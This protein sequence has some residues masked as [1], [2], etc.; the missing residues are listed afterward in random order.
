MFK[1]MT[2]MLLIA[3]VIFG[4]IFGVSLFKRHMMGQYFANFTPPPRVVS[5][6]YAQLETWRPY[7]S[8]IGT[9]KAVNG[10]DLS[11]EVEGKVKAIHFQ[12]GQSVYE[13]ELLLEIDDEVEQAN[14]KSLEARLKLARLN[15]QRDEKLIQ[16][17]L[18]SQEQI[19]RSRAELDEVV[20]L[21]EQ[22]KAV[23]AK[24]K[25]RAPFAGKVGIREVNLGQYLSKGDT[26]TNLQAMASL[27][28]DFSL[29]EL[30][31]TKVFVGQSL[32]FTV[33]AYPGQEFSAR[34]IAL[35]AKV[36]DTTRNIRVRAEFDNFNALLVPG[37]FA[38]VQLLLRDAEEVI[39]VPKTA[40]TYSLYGETIYR[41]DTADTD[42]NDKVMAVQRV[43]V[44]TG[45]VRGQRVAVT[46][47]IAAGDLVVTD[48]Q[49]KLK[50]GTQI[51]LANANAL[52]PS[53]PSV[54]PADALH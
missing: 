28:L 12:S 54:E 11:G 30:E 39:S 14:L 17:K 37:M 16:K 38:V 26:L 42:Q 13:G 9:L 41:V 7:L 4:G 44:T 45:A 32:R 40:V 52:A 2:V 51:Q 20:A 36:D 49:I 31:F 3:G 19:D 53:A 29:P 47:G 33:D 24:K 27:Y 10:V 21:V 50:N 46:S 43:S 22:T 25:I 34:V 8:A 48:G 15:Y 18:T 6:A 5:G 23:I 1:R 35:N